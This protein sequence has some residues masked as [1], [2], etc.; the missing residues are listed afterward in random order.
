MTNAVAEYH[1][2][3]FWSQDEKKVFINVKLTDVEVSASFF[4]FV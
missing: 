3:L 1:P 4:Q 2:P